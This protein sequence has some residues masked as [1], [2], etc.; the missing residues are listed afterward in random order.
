MYF[1]FVYLESQLQSFKLVFCCY[2]R[3]QRNTFQGIV[4]TNGTKTYA[5][6]TYRC[7]DIQWETSNTTVIGFNAG[8]TSYDNHPLSG[9][10]DAVNIDCENS[11]QSIWNNIVYD[12]NPLGSNS[13]ATPPLR[14]EDDNLNRSY[15][16]GHIYQSKALFLCFFYM[17]TIIILILHLSVRY[18]C[19][20]GRSRS[21]STRAKNFSFSSS[22]D[23]DVAAH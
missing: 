6:F 16:G 1:V 5:V 9:T 19:E 22:L 23:L 12:V 15:A 2:A 4:I 8:G 20:S 14:G 10:P 13:S 3:P 7:D 18:V 17:V 21:H 11:P